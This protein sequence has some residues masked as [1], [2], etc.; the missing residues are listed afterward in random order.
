V[1]KTLI[2]VL[3]ATLGSVLPHGP[4]VSSLP[5]LRS[6]SP[7]KVGYCSGLKSLE[8]AKA[9][10][11]DYV[12]LSATEIASLSDEEFASAASRVK[13]LGIPTPTANLFLPATLKVTGA[14][15]HP[16]QQ[17]QHVRRVLS[18]LATL[19]TEIVVFGSG[20]A[21]RVPDGFSR[22]EAFTQLV[23]FSRRAARE[24]RANGITIA[25]EPL[26]RQETNIINTAAEG[27]D[28]V[29][30]VSDPNFELMIDFYHLASEHED[31]AIVFKAKDHL[32]H[33]HT[34]NPKGRVFPQVWDEFDYAPF[35]ADLRAIGYDKRISVEASTPDLLIQAPPAIA[36]LRR[37]FSPMP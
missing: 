15:V 37:A 35:F 14:D 33:L 7:V 20:G 6:A 22:E 32:R 2:V 18:R 34:A 3:L 4:Y 16:D 8:A 1:T 28:L 11:F 10:G 13:A 30:T 26:R 23:D 17:M 9:A 27:L 21:R 31:P 24:A 5:V 19:G 12:E 36:L 25:I 29:N